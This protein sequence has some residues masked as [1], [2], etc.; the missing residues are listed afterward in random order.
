MG[1]QTKIGTEAMTPSLKEQDTVLGYLSLKMSWP[2]VERKEVEMKDGRSQ[3]LLESFPPE[4]F[5]SSKSASTTF[6]L[7]LV[8]LKRNLGLCLGFSAK[9][10]PW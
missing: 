2:Q 3:Q 1:G 5:S 10:D 4:P 8:K 7:H 6:Y 9:S